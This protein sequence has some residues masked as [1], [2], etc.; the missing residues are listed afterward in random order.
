[1]TIIQ[2]FLILPAAVASTFL[3]SS[4]AQAA[5]IVMDD[6]D[7]GFQSLSVNAGDSDGSNSAF[8]GSI[9]GGSRTLELLNVENQP[10]ENPP[11]GRANL[12]VA[13]SS[14]IWSNDFAVNSIAKVS[15]DSNGNGLG[16]P[17]NPPGVDLTGQTGINV[18]FAGGDAGVNIKFILTD[19][20]GNIVMNSQEVSNPNTSL[21][22]GF[23]GFAGDNGF[24][25]NSVESV[26]MELTAER[27]AAD[28]RIDLL[29]APM[30]PVPE[31]LT[32]LGSAT[33]LGLGSLLK[34]EHS[35]KQNKS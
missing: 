17:A 33:A 28:L 18:R 4:V 7:S 19:T 27:P 23:G 1:M 20:M 22:F 14:L 9:L 25:L 3:F 5:S 30:K 29:E 32:I 34:R 11:F 8:G 31:P 16:S 13:G 2:Q 21:L 6:F 24:K 26:M 35:K 10:P 15:W 12:T